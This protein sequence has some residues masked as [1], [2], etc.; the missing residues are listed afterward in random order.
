MVD[1]GQVKISGVYLYTH[2]DATELIEN[3]QRALA[4]RWRWHDHEYLA[5]II[6]DEMKLTGKIVQKEYGTV[7]VCDVGETGY[8]IGSEQHADICRLIEI[9]ADNKVIVTDC[10]KEIFNGSFEDFLKFEELLRCEKW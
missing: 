1:R 8:G 9:T 2:W 7:A 5:R 6:F 3:V 4:K 10:D